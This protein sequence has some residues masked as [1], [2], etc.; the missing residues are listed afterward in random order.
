MIISV[1]FVTAE[2]SEEINFCRFLKIKQTHCV[3]GDKQFSA[4]FFDNY[5]QN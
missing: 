1:K 4:E 5:F 3:S 2:N